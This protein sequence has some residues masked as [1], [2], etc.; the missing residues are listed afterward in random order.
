MRASRR[1]VERVRDEKNFMN[2]QPVCQA[3]EASTRDVECGGEPVGRVGAL[4]RPCRVQR[5]KVAWLAGGAPSGPPA[6]RGRG[7]RSAMSLPAG[8]PYSDGPKPLAPCCR[9]RYNSRH[10]FDES[11]SWR[12]PAIR[13]ITIRIKRFSWP[14]KTLLPQLAARSV[15]RTAD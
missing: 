3:L 15:F 12:I 14:T 4:R 6:G 7:H 8:C 13:K 11:R 5:R 10:A 2:W 9:V 1:T